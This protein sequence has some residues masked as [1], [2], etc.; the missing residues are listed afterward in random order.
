MIARGAFGIAGRLVVA[1]GTLVPLVVDRPA[2]V[3]RGGNQP[4]GVKSPAAAV[5][6]SC[7]LPSVELAAATA[8]EPAVR[9][10]GISDLCVERVDAQRWRAWA[11]TD[12]GPNGTVTVG[13]RTQRTLLSPSFTPCIIQLAID[14]DA[15]DPRRLSVAMTGTITL[16]DR[17]GRPLSGRPNGAAGDPRMLNPSGERAITPDPDGVDP[18]GLIRTSSGAW[19]L[20]EEYRPSLLAADADGTVSQRHLPAGQSLAGAGMHVADSLPGP[21]AGRRD[22]RGFE[23]LAIAP[24]ETRLFALVQSPLERCDRETAERLGSVRLLAFDPAAGLPV[25]EYVYRLGD[26]S[27]RKRCD[28]AEPMDGKLCA[29]AALGPDTLL[30]LEQGVRGV[31][32][33]YLVEL[34][35]ATD[36]LPRTQAGDEPALESLHDIEAAGI[37]PVTKSLVADLGP[38]LDGMRSEAGLHGSRAGPLKIEGL[39]VADRR[40]VFLVNDDDFGVREDAGSPAARSCLWVLRLP[41][42]LPLSPH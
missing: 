15:A 33:L 3:A 4:E 25:A 2:G 28:D 5:M 18:E 17:D 19:W 26:P 41:Q 11:V 29:M 30:V 37:M 35:S 36:T 1:G 24:D 13:G 38:V 10:G 9:L 21:Y 22:N 32:L 16:R 31:A 27:S 23:A 34:G 7:I 39:A 42:S 20:A 14:W 12:R 8:A 6:A 40:H